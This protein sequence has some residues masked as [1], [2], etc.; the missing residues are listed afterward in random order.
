M[1]DLA[2]RVQRLR[3]ETAE[4]LARTEQVL[5]E[6]QKLIAVVRATKGDDL[7]WPRSDRA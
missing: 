5:I 3:T 7:T 1:V 4:V 6:T 2:A